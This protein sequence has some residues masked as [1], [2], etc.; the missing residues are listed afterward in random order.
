LE[1]G[2]EIPSLL[3]TGRIRHRFAWQRRIRIPDVAALPRDV[4]SRLRRPPRPV[5]ALPSWRSSLQA[6]HLTRGQPPHRGPW[7]QAKSG[8]LRYRLSPELNE[9]AASLYKQVARLWFLSSPP[10]SSVLR[11]TSR[12]APVSTERLRS[13]HRA[14]RSPSGYAPIARQ[15][16]SCGTVASEDR[17]RCQQCPAV[18]HSVAFN[19]WASASAAEC[20]K[21]VRGSWFFPSAGS[22]VERSSTV[23]RPVFGRS[24]QTT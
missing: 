24:Y 17:R 20:D 15:R 7:P 18:I 23:K 8:A 13:S 3:G 5:H 4:N 19:F 6:G 10:S 11:L 9:P 21:P 1:P 2:A 22:S 14:L 12:S 16:R